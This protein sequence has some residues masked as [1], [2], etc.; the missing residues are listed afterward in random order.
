VGAQELTGGVGREASGGRHHL[1]E[2]GRERNRRCD[3]NTDLNVKQSSGDLREGGKKRREKLQ[4]NTKGRGRV[5]LKKK[6]KKNYKSKIQKDTLR[7]LRNDKTGK[8][9]VAPK[10]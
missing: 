8:K 4:H 2:R 6:K 1:T 3:K 7:K 9:K 10:S 5:V